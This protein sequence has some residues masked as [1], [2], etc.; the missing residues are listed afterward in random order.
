MK[1]IQIK[2]IDESL[3]Y[4]KLENG[5][6]VYM[7]PK[8]TST[9]TF[10][11]FTTKY[12]GIHNEFKNSDKKKFIKVPTGIAHFLEHKMF[13]QEDGRDPFSFFAESGTYCNAF[14]NYYNTSYLFSGNTELENNLNYLLD[15]VQK[16][17]FTDENVEKEKGIIEQEIKMY[18]DKADRIIYEKLLYNIFI[19]HPMKYSIAG[20]VEDIRKI[21]KEDLYTCYNTFYNPN[22]MFLVLTGNFN[23]EDIINIIKEN[24]NKKEFEKKE[25]PILKDYIEPNKVA[26]KHDQQ[27][28]NIDTPYLSFGIKIPLK[29]I[30]NMDHKKRNLYFATCFYYLFGET[31]EFNERIT[32]E[33]LL[34]SSLDIEMIDTKD[35]KIVILV[36]KSKKYD[37][38]LFNIDKHLKDINV[39]EDFLERRKKVFK[40]SLIYIYENISDINRNILDNIITYGKCDCDIYDIVDSLNKEELDKMILKLDLSNTSTFIIKPIKIKE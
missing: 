34:D 1:K 23:P 29:N 4:E 35:H 9:E 24:Q 5:M 38:L 10:A 36:C 33:K 14:T 11:S 31:S 7:V 30:K 16:P 32:N 3:Y 22:N 12:G 39:D 17:Y 18:D 25:I 20:R 37:E 2:N 8:T 19:N 21:T 13:E 15:F 6:E 40:S 28:M 26:K 27:K